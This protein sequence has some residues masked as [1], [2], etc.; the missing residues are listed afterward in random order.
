MVLMNPMVL[1]RFAGTGHGEQCAVMAGMKE[2]LKL[3]ADNL[4]LIQE[5]TCL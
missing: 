2:M 5:V 1:W 4:D 3:H